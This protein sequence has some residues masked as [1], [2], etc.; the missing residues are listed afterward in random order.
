MEKIIRIATRNSPLAL[1]QAEIAKQILEKSN[2][3]DSCVLI[4]MT[5][6]GDKVNLESFRKFGGKGLFIKELEAALFNRTADVA[7]HSLKDVPAKL[8]NNFSILTID[9]RVDAC[10]VFVSNK[11]KSFMDLPSNAKIGTSSPRRKSQLKIMLKDISIVEIQG[12]IQTRIE[13]MKTQKLDGIILAS[14]AIERLNIKNLFIDKISIKNFTPSA[15]QGILG[16]ETMKDNRKL[17]KEISGLSNKNTQICAKAERSFI[18]K[19]NGDCF[20]PIGVHAQIQGSSI[21]INGFVSDK[22]GENFIKS[23]Y[24]ADLDDPET[25]GL[26]FAKI[27]IKQGAKKLIKS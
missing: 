17:I 19:L 13:K 2:C 1:K 22:S 26:D 3:F 5:T 12:N 27:F 7:V 25:A 20:S 24:E 6:T 15:G 10:D 8:N 18:Y 4:P 23:K 14:A 21:I 9:E 16:I 11:Y